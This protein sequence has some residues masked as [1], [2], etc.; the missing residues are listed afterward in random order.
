MSELLRPL[1][2]S[3]AASHNVAAVVV[4]IVRTE[5]EISQGK[6]CVLRSGFAGFTLVA[7]EWL[8]GIPVYRRVTQRRWPC[9]RFLFVESELGA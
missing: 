1:L 2:T 3:P 6:L 7:Y 8:S 9:I 4:R 5:R